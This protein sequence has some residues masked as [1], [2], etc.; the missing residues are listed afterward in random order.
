MLMHNSAPTRISWLDGQLR[1]TPLIP[2]DNRG[3]LVGLGVFETLKVTDS[4]PEFLERHINRLVESTQRIDVS[5]HDELDIGAAIAEVIAAN[6]DIAISARLRITVTAQGSTSSILI[7]MAELEPY[8]ETTSCI[9]VPWARN[10][11]SPLSGVKSTSYA[12]NVI[13]LNWARKAGYS[14]AIFCDSVGRLSEGATTNIFLVLNGEVLTPSTS[15]GLLPGVIRGVLLEAKLAKEAD[16]LPEHLKSAE[17]I[18]LTSS[19]RGVHPVSRINDRVFESVG[20]ATQQTLKRFKSL[21]K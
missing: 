6:Q 8:P 7:S 15:S 10:E 13:A 3:F 20:Q 21:R 17:E 2:S 16:L 5:L 14:E 18:F 11:R 1:E 4:H 19:T 12:E 9:E